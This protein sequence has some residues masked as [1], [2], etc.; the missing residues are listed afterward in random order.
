MRMFRLNPCN[1][2]PA[3]SWNRHLRH[4]DSRRRQAVIRRRHSR[5]IGR[6]MIHAPRQHI[7]QLNGNR[8]FRTSVYASRCGTGS[9][10]PMAHIALAHNAPVFIKLRHAVRTIPRAILTADAGIGAVQ[11]NACGFIFRVSFHRTADH[12]SRLQ[13]MVTA[14]RH[15]KALRLGVYSTFNFTHTPPVD[16][17]RISVLFITGNHTTL[18]PDAGADI[19]VKAV[20]FPCIRFTVGNQ[21]FFVI[22]QQREPVVMLVFQQWQFSGQL[23]PPRAP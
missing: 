17:C 23:A 1:I 18:A 22:H 11:H 19:E 4:R 3:Q 5:R 9:K 13:A 21:T 14:H 8:T 15:V 12:T 6:S 10:P 20:L 2:H 16:M 7:Y